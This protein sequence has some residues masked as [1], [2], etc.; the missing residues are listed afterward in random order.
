MNAD[1][2]RVGEVLQANV[3]R[4]TEHHLWEAWPNESK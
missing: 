3:R 4:I 1:L 2:Q